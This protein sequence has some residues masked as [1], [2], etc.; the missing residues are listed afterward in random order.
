MRQTPP[1]PSRRRALRAA[2]TPGAGHGGV[3]LFRH[4]YLL[5]LLLLGALGR[6]GALRMQSKARHL[7]EQLC[8]QDMH[9]LIRATMPTAAGAKGLAALLRYEYFDFTADYQRVAPSSAQLGAL[10]A[11][12]S[13]HP[14]AADHL[15]PMRKVQ[16][17]PALRRR[18][19]GVIASPD[20][21][22]SPWPATVLSDDLQITQFPPKHWPL[23]LEHAAATPSQLQRV[24]SLPFCAHMN[25]SIA[26]RLVGRGERHHRAWIL[27]DRDCLEQIRPP[28]EQRATLCALLARFARPSRDSDGGGDDDGDVSALLLVL[29]RLAHLVHSVVDLDAD[30][31]LLVKRVQ[32]RLPATLP[33]LDH[34]E[35][36]ARP[37]APVARSYAAFE[38]LQ[39]MLLVHSDQPGRM[40]LEL[41]LAHEA[42]RRRIPSATVYATLLFQQYPPSH[43][44]PYHSRRL[45]KALG[46]TA[47][48]DY[49]YGIAWHDL[50]RQPTLRLPRWFPL[51]L[52]TK[53][54]R[55]NAWRRQILTLSDQTHILYREAAD[56]VSDRL[57]GRVWTN[58][59][60]S[61]TTKDASTRQLKW[62][63]LLVLQAERLRSSPETA[64]VGAREG[65][66]VYRCTTISPTDLRIFWAA[67][68]ARY[69]LQASQL[70]LPC[71]DMLL[72]E[73]G[74]SSLDWHR[75]C[76]DQPL[77]DGS[78][79]DRLARL[80]RE[81]RTIFAAYKIP[82]LFY[83][84]T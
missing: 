76:L 4:L 50:A 42:L 24:E 2:V 14:D 10:L 11:F 83:K 46:P 49:S 3:R 37:E 32:D 53:K 63:R 51:Q 25:S 35:A 22:S 82:S 33:L 84:K 30:L 52:A 47:P 12:A 40:W 70:M 73:L 41:E 78:D 26:E 72:A 18:L 81:T 17:Q 39:E 77:G 44:P 34:L 45:L 27:I 60:V 57:L 1:S 7:Y 16:A 38:A 69:A 75:C 61:L 79:A 59:H 5:L 55:L 29:L 68:F 31:R 15:L 71:K 80:V 28:L 21:A 43:L 66:I 56:L 64:V 67:S 19:L 36:W 20:A 48:L 13:H 8:P 54:Q 6:A 62:I 74:P 23:L 9:L 58:L 65:R